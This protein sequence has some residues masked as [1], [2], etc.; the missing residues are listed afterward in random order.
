LRATRGLHASEAERNGAAILAAIKT[1]LACPSSEWPEIPRERKPEPE[2]AGLVE[3]L[4]AVLKAC[5]LE[6][7]IAPSLLA[8][9]ADLQQ[10]AEAK[11]R[12]ES[13]DVPVLQGWRRKLAGE[14]L[15]QVLE[16]KISVSVDQKSGKLRI[17]CS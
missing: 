5:A 14:C 10:L 16:G 17:S 2:A 6:A 12:R 9:A 11:G 1:G 3:L 8:S 13:V 4:Q 7:E 15:L